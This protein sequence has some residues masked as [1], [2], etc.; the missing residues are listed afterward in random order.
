MSENCRF[1]L[2]AGRWVCQNPGC[3]WSRR[4]KYGTP[5]HRK[6]DAPL[7]P[8]LLAAADRLGLPA[9]EARRYAAGLLTWAEAGFPESDPEYRADAEAICRACEWKAEKAWRCKQKCPDQ[10]CAAKKAR[11]PLEYRLAMAT[12]SCPLGRW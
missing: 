4:D 12:E 9:Q 5:P 1:Q 6:C 2:V 8:V 10:G 11:L 7:A 3:G